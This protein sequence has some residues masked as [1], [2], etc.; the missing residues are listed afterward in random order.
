MGSSGPS[1]EYTMV[2]SL[3]VATLSFIATSLMA[4]ATEAM[5]SATGATTTT[6]TPTMAA[7]LGTTTTERGQ[8][9][10][11]LMLMPKLMLMLI[12]TLLC[13]TMDSSPATVPTAT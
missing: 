3:A 5:V 2:R 8:L 13:T 11:R 9:V 1:S 7:T 10:L 6:A 4:M 12:P